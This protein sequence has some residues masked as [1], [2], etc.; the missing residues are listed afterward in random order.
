MPV[1]GSGIIYFMQVNFRSWNFGAVGRSMVFEERIRTQ[2]LF[3][4]PWP[5]KSLTW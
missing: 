5:T 2:N 1:P 4:L 3:P